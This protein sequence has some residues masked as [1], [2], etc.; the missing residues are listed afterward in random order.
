MLKAK[1]ALLLQQTNLN[2]VAIRLK[3]L[4]YFQTFIQL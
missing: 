4:V 2:M 3:E 1:Q